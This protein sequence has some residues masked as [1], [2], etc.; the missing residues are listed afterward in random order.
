MAIFWGVMR[1]NKKISP[2]VKN[3]T[4][5][6]AAK[7]QSLDYQPLIKT[8]ATCDCPVPVSGR[9]QGVN[10]IMCKYNAEKN[11]PNVKRL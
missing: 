8:L 1:E 5:S 3:D 2:T 10:L 4:S 9:S 7:L 11:E 6:R